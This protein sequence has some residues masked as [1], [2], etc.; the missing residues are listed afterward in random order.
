LLFATPQ[1]TSLVRL[2]YTLFFFKKTARSYF[3]ANPT[4]KSPQTVYISY[5]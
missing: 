3:S 2:N 4:K 1:G 5:Q